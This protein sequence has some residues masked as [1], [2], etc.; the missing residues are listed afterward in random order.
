[1]LLKGWKILNRI[2]WNPEALQKEA[3]TRQ[4]YVPIQIL[5]PE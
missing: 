5:E 4:L 2:G 3:S 1:M